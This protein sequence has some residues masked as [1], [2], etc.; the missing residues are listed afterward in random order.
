[1]KLASNSLWTFSAMALSLSWVKTFFFF[2]TGGKDKETLSWWTIIL[3]SIPGMSLWLKAKTSRLFFRKRVSSL[4]TKGLAYVPIWEIKSEWSSSRKI[5]SKAFV[6]STI[7]VDTRGESPP[8]FCNGLG[9]IYI[10]RPLRGRT[11]DLTTRVRVW[12]L[13]MFLGR[14]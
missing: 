9:T 6:G 1:M 8:S 4:Q 2:L 11:F 13:G 10:L 5:S 7:I 3:R 14:C 12:S